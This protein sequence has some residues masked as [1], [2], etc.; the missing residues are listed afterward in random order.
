MSYPKVK[1]KCAAKASDHQ[2]AQCND[3]QAFSASAR[4]HES[5]GV[6]Q[7]AVYADWVG[8]I[9]YLPVSQRLIGAY[10][11]IFDLFIDAPGDKHLPRM[12]NSLKPGCNVNAIP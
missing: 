8:D 10:E 9:L 12:G 5:V 7:H 2:N 11:F 6:G 3:Y 1:T 4:S